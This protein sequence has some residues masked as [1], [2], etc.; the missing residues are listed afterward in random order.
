MPLAEIKSRIASAC[1]KYGRDPAEVTL[2]AVSKTQPAEKISALLDQ[3][4]Y[5]F[6][7]NRLQEAEEK[8]PGLRGEYKNI[9]LHFIGHLQTNKAKDAVRV[10][11]MIETVDSPRL[12]AALG[13]EMEKQKRRLPCLIQVNT[14]DE[15]QKG[16]VAPQELES[17]FRFCTEEAGLN[18]EGLMCIP[19]V[20]EIPDLHFALLHKLAKGLSLQKLSMG[21]SAD[22]ETAIRYGATHLR[23]GSALFGARKS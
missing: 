1:K 9:E 23:I 15:E 17:L 22:F 3:G 7:E 5:V 4:Q 19:P 11:D 2:V 13:A 10:F 18:I 12:A 20:H 16:G 8:F 14:G 6:G 21:M